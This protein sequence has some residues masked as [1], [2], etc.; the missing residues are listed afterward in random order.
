MAQALLPDLLRRRAPSPSRCN[1]SKGG[2]A[3][4]QSL[5]TSRFGA[6]Y[7]SLKRRPA[8]ANNL[9]DK[10]PEWLKSLYNMENELRSAALS[11]LVLHRREACEHLA[12]ARGHL[13]ET[14]KAA[15]G[16]APADGPQTSVRKEGEF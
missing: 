3:S 14:L 5:G 15:R 16:E 12:A 13:Q 2:G 7:A 8:M 1:R 11:G 10:I 9:T 4:P 6:G